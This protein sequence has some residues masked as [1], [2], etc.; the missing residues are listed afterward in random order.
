M[1]N[2]FFGNKMLL[3]LS[4]ILIALILAGLMGYY[5]VGSKAEVLQSWTTCINRGIVYASGE[6]FVP[7]ADFQSGKHSWDSGRM[8][9]RLVS[10]LVPIDDYTLRSQGIEVSADDPD[11]REMILALQ[12][13]DE[14]SVDED[15]KLVVADSVDEKL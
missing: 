6:M 2:S 14:N 15:G 9:F 13:Q 12:E 3:K 1:K 4:R 7:I 10:L 5:F 8:L 11:T